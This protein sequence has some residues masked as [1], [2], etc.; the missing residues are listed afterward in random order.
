MENKTKNEYLLEFIY[1]IRKNLPRRRIYY[2]FYFIFKFNGM[3]LSTSNL[4]NYETNDNHITSMHSILSLLSIFHSSFKI[5]NDNY[6]IYSFIIFL[7]CLS[8]II[9]YTIIYLK[10]KILF[11][12]SKTFIEDEINKLLHKTQKIEIHFNIITKIIIFINFFSSLIKEYLI[13]GVVSPFIKNILTDNS[14]IQIKNKNYISYYFNDQNMSN[15]IIMI[16]NIFS[17]IIFSFIEFIFLILNNIQC[18]FS[19]YG[20]PLYLGGKQNIFIFLLTLFQPIYG[21][22]FIFQDELRNKFR[23]YSCMILVIFLTILIF[24]NIH[25]YTF[26]YG[27]FIPIFNFEVI[28]FCWYNGIIEL[29]LYNII[30]DKE[31]MTQDFSLIKLIISIF[32]SLL[33]LSILIY[34]NIEYYNNLFSKHLFS[35]EEK[36]TFVGEIYEFIRAFLNSKDLKNKTLNSLCQ[37][38]SVHKQK[39]TLSSCIC[40]SLF[41]TLILNNENRPQYLN[42]GLII[43]GEQEINNRIYILYKTKK[44]NKTLEYYCILHVQYIYAISQKKYLA[45][46]FANKYLQCPLKINILSYYYLY[47]IKKQILK[48]SFSKK[49]IFEDDYI[50]KINIE[51][52]KQIYPILNHLQK[53]HNFSIFTDVL[54]KLILDNFVNLQI[55]FSFRKK[56]MNKSSKLNSL[57]ENNFRMFIKSCELIK[58]NDEKIQNLIKIFLK[59]KTLHNYEVCYLLTNYFILIHHQIPKDISK[60]FDEHYHFSLISNLIENDDIEFNM[61]HPMII[62]LSNNSDIFLIS[63]INNIFCENLGYSKKNIINSDFQDLIP[64]QI[65]KEHNL[66]MKKFLFFNNPHFSK[67]SYVLDYEKYLTQCYFECRLLPDF[68]NS[69][70]IIINFKLLTNEDKDTIFYSVFI[71]KDFN[72]VSLCRDFEQLFFFNMKMFDILNINFCQFFGLNESNLRKNLKK[73]RKKLKI[74]SFWK[75]ENKAYLIFSNIPQEKMFKYRTTKSMTDIKK[76]VLIYTENIEKTQIIEG[77]SNLVKIIEENG[78]DIEWYKRVKYLGE[79]LKVEL[80][81]HSIIQHLSMKNENYYNSK[82]F[83]ATFYSKYIG[84]VPYC[85]V[86]IKERT[87]VKELVESTFD[88]NLK[89]NN[90]N[91]LQKRLSFFN[92]QLTKTFLEKNELNNPKYKRELSN[93]SPKT[94]TSI[95]NYPLIDNLNN[96]VNFTFTDLNSSTSNSNIIN[97]KMGLLGTNNIYS[98]DK[99]PVYNMNKKNFKNEMIPIP[100]Q[101]NVYKPIITIQT[102]FQDFKNKDLKEDYKKELLYNKKFVSGEESK[103]YINKIIILLYIII[104][105]LAFILLIIKKEIIKEHRN[106]F[107]C[108]TY[109]EMLKTDLY[110]SSLLSLRLCFDM[111]NNSLHEMLYEYVILWKIHNLREHSANFNYYINS[112][113]EKSN[114]KNIFKLLYQGNEFLYLTYDWSISKR[115]TNIFEE[116][117]LFQ[118]LLSQNYFNDDIRCNISHFIDESFIKFGGIDDF[119]TSHHEKLTFYS[120]YNILQKYKFIF[121]ELSYFTFEILLKFNNDFFIDVLSFSLSIFLISIICFILLFRKLFNDKDEIKQIL[122]Y[123]FKFSIKEKLFE[124][125]VKNFIIVLEEFNGN[126]IYNFEE[127]KDKEIKDETDINKEIKKK[128]SYRKKKLNRQVNDTSHIHNSTI[129]NNNLENII[130]NKEE[131]I[132]NIGENQPKILLPKVF[133]FSIITSIICFI[134]ITLII[135]VNI[136]YSIKTKRNL[137]Y[138]IIFSMNFLQR[139]PKIIELVQYVEIVAI[140]KTSSLSIKDKIIFNKE[141]Y[142]NYYNLQ[143]SEETNSIINSINDTYFSNLF[144][145]GQIC[146]LNIRKFKGDSKQVLKALKNLEY[147]FNEKNNLCKNSAENSF[148]NSTFN[149]KTEFD[150]NNNVTYKEMMCKIFCSSTNENGLEIEIDYIYQEITNNYVDYVKSNST[151]NSY[152]LIYNKEVIRANNDLFYVFNLVF[153]SY[154][155]CIL[156]ENEN[157]NNKMKRDEEIISIFLIIVLCIII[158]QIFFVFRKTEKYRELFLFF[159]KM[160]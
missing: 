160:Y 94:K 33:I 6:Q 85:I 13:F 40:N 91:I 131:E 72:F 11:R 151:D 126:T 103:N 142:L 156:K 28:I 52:H 108:N 79:R 19:R 20:K 14:K 56:M 111:S 71:D 39:C 90:E 55:V 116:I 4:R 74:N 157:N 101:F 75:K 114:L 9:Y 149:S 41:K 134:L 145:Y 5:I 138:S 115:N 125:Q 123:I 17:I 104:G 96:N 49:L 141:K 119:S 80:P 65:K 44:I 140:L 34:N 47:E 146:E 66:I 107:A 143:L 88:I 109:I 15:Q 105:I 153:Q 77:L 48:E 1:L 23:F 106:L 53:F 127:N 135:S 117:N 18:I 154:A 69:F 98:H 58:K 148:L 38:I 78:L 16:F 120:I 76:N 124:K 2:V 43:V 133:I 84:F 59:D 118:Y 93:I 21:Y 31:K 57:N 139:I 26:Y 51:E 144:I 62:T 136:I 24:S 89:L 8:F 46:Y 36:N 102:G 92:P 82:R 29:I 147:S 100:A 60:S 25:D 95:K 159:H 37:L 86:N 50:G 155:K 83:E 150:Y 45:L 113:H 130:K 12:D 81:K 68:K 61:K 122:L 121:E 112:L 27:S 67:K 10:F 35:V 137:K 132:L 99:N 97:S 129:E 42:K 7:F 128:K 63:Y 32:T 54:N 158:I 22:S 70:H 152:N 87:D 30:K 3:I 73:K 110:L 64:F